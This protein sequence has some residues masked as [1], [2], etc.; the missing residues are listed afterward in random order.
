MS[1][2]FN[3]F[4]KGR[5]TLLVLIVAGIVS[6]I[7]AFALDIGTQRT[8]LG[9][10]NCMMAAGALIVA[11]YVAPNFKLSWNGR[12]AGVVFFFMAFVTQTE[13]ALLVLDSSFIRTREQIYEVFIIV[14]TLE[15]VSLVLFLYFIADATDRRR[16]KK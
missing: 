3:S 16:A 10:A 11:I 2:F 13:W 4:I 9:I 7:V 1:N 14:H 5:A 12:L 8:W 6:G 15:A